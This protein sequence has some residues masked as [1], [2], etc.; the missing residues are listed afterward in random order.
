MKR[1]EL[2]DIDAR[3]QVVK[4]VGKTIAFV[5]ADNKKRV[6]DIIVEM[7]KQKEP[8]KE[9]KDYVD[10]VEKLK[11][12]FSEKDHIGRPITRNGNYPNGTPGRFYA[13]PGSEDPES[14]YRKALK[15]IEIKNKKI[16]L[17][18][19]KR[20]QDYWDVYLEQELEKTL[21]LR[22][23]KY[24]EV[25]KEINQDQMDALLFIIEYDINAKGDVR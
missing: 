24:V 13:I 15:V 3:L 14:E 8:S 4:Q 21:D 1:K 10:E 16:I 22:K 5:I 11:R 6:S 20:E 7:E 25:P 2:Y 17:D 18:Q 12:K 9:F 23:I 19:E